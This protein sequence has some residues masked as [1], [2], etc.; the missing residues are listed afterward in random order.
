MENRLQLKVIN[1]IKK[2]KKLKKAVAKEY[3][4]PSLIQ[5]QKLNSSS[6]LLYY[7]RL[8]RRITLHNMALR[9]NFALHNII[10]PYNMKKSLY[11]Y[12]TKLS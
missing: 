3:R 2:R 10:N 5:I 1:E 12:F 8:I 6:T 7:F 9:L 4:D 11:Q